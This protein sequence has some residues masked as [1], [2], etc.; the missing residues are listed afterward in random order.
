MIGAVK[1]FAA[2]TLGRIAIG[3]ALTLCALIAV[4]WFQNGHL[5]T[6]ATDAEN[7]A[8]LAEKTTENTTIALVAAENTVAI[9]RNNAASQTA[10]EEALHNEPETFDCAASP[11]VRSAL[12]ILRSRQAI[13]DADSD[14]G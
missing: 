8:A 14:P 6:R 4:L 11:A 13:R 12:D 9:R 5:R 7:A 1:A 3:V 2:N 10:D